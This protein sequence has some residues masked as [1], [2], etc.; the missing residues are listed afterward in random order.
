MGRRRAGR[1]GLGVDV[2][3][4][5]ALGVLR[6]H[7]D[8]VR[9]GKDVDGVVRGFRGDLLVAVGAEPVCLLE[10]VEAA[11]KGSQADADETEDGAGQAAQV[12]LAS[13]LEG[14]FVW[15]RTRR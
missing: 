9:H 13:G 6:G 11:R 4:R 15:A 14:R 2:C 12:V 10:P 5:H 3:R 1:V 8:D 7:D